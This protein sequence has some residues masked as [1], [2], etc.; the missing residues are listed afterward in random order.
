MPCRAL[1]FST[2]QCVTQH[3]TLKAVTSH[4]IRVS[5]SFKN[6]IDSSNR[7]FGT[8]AIKTN[9]YADINSSVV[10]KIMNRRKQRFEMMCQTACNWTKRT[11]NE[12]SSI[13]I[14]KT[15]INIAELAFYANTIYSV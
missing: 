3:R 14:I 5:K 7:E 1:K 10:E 4:S 12:E 15:N 11:F 9:Y 13:V 6:L 2:A 8:P